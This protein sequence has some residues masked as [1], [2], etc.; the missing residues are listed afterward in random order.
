MIFF[1]A[2][3]SI[4]LF[5]GASQLFANNLSIA[6]VELVG[7]DSSADTIKI[8]FD[9]TWSN[10][11]RDSVNYD[12]VWI[13]AKYCTSSCTGNG[14][15]SH[16]I[17]K[18]SGTNPSGFDDGTKQSSSN[19]TA[20]DLIIPSDKVGVFMQPASSGSGTVNFNDAQ[21]VWDYAQNGLSDAN[22]IAATTYVRVYGIEMVYIP[23][24]GF[25]I[26]DANT[27]GE[28]QFEFRHS[29]SSLPAPVTSENAIN[30][31]DVTNAAEQTNTLKWY[32]NTDTSADDA[33]SGS[34]FDLD[35]HFPKGF[36]AFYLMKYE[37]SQGEY[38]NFLNTLTQ[39][40]QATRVASDITNENDANTY[41]MVVEGQATV[42]G[43]Q[44]IKAGSNPPNGD[45]YAFTC[46]FD[47]NDT[48]NQSGDGEWIA[49]NY[50]S[51][52]DLLAYADWAGLRPM[53]EFEYE[54]AAR[55]PAAYTTDEYAWGTTSLT[56]VTS[57][58]N[59]GQTSEV[60]GQSGNGLVTYNNAGGV[61]GPMRV[62]YAATS[63]TT[64]RLA[65]STGFYGNLDLS[66]NVWEHVVTVGNATGRAFAGT[67]GDGILT[68]AGNATNEDWPGFSSGNGV[69]GATGSSFR[70]GAWDETTATYL[71]T[72][73]RSFG[74][75]TDT[76]RR[77]D[78][79]GRLARTAE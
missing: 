9:I 15:W 18:S 24:G 73:D 19:F 37:M 5:S 67:N 48:G 74:G 35:E 36:Q 4:S 11:W 51:W 78:T 26:S 46:D 55:G 41:V 60:A 21:I 59:S 56:A 50:L 49:M 38:R 23:E 6:N 69:N 76:T 43:R 42:T 61:T 75:D 71:N 31:G 29:A 22:A 20:L 17:L 1:A 34:T 66:G 72:S 52:M 62:G 47:D 30:F 10:S 58:T 64:T 57:I 39:A 12:A 2:L 27:G 14:T 40:G 54:K 68:T 3:L 16:A 79:G 70:G 44:A 77:A 63:T 7:Q 65:A 28:G 32:Y 13:F 33:A 25:T 8:E 45:P 53:T